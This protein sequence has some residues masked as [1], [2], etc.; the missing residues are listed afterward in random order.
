MLRVQKT[1]VKFDTTNPWWD[2]MQLGMTEFCN[3]DKYLPIRFSVYSFSNSGPNQMYGSVTCTTRDIEM[4]PEA[5][6]E[7]KIKDSKG[8][9]TGK[10]EFKQF[11]MDMKPSLVEYLTNGWE[12]Q[13]SIGIDFTLSNLEIT[14]P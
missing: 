3:N 8:K 10:L 14:D 2:T 4:L 13:V 7:M 9:V 12:M 1:G 11:D 5:K 6:K